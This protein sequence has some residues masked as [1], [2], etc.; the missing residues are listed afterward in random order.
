MSRV[1]SSTHE[2]NRHDLSGL[3]A[4]VLQRLAVQVKELALW[5]ACDAAYAS[6]VLSGE[7]PLSGERI[8]QL[9]VHVQVELAREWGE[10]LGLLVG[11]KAA[12]IGALTAA[13]YLLAVDERSAG[14]PL[15]AGPPIKAELPDVP[16]VPARRRA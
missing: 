9:P 7:K 3:L 8:S 6:R 2:V 11:A 14:L 4:I 16:T 1:S 10:A 12:A 15:K 5:W 13:C